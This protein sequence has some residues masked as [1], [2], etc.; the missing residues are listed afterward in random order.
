M[1]KLDKANEGR[2][3]STKDE[4]F[5]EEGPWCWNCELN[6]RSY[7]DEVVDRL[8]MYFCSRECRKEWEAAQ[9][10]QNLLDKIGLT[11]RE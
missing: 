5:W 6:I 7:N 2:S 4:T 8:P 11:K 10:L 9:P 1:A 3:T